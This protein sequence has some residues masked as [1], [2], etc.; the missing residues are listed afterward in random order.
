M[1]APS[2]MVSLLQCGLWWQCLAVVYWPPQELAASALQVKRCSLLQPHHSAFQREV[3]QTNT[4]AE[5]VPPGDLP[6]AAVH[7]SVGI[8][9]GRVNLTS[10]MCQ[11]STHRAA[12]QA[13]T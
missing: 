3:T 9:T 6:T 2:V 10:G 13:S 5:Q 7:V 1:H 4:P 8:R 12:L 11:S